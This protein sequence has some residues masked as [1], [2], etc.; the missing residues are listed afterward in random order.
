VGIALLALGLFFLFYQTDR[1]IGLLGIAIAV[2]L[3]SWVARSLGRAT[4]RSRYLRDRWRPRDLAVVASSLLFIAGTFYAR[5]FAAG[6]FVYSAFP[7]ATLPFFHPWSIGSVLLLI[8][9]AAFVIRL[10]ERAH[11]AARSG[12]ASTRR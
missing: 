5:E 7:R 2:L 9:P 11:T 12:P 8:V 6:V 10:E 1:R 3:L 4:H